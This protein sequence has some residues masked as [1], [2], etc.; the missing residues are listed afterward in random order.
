MGSGVVDPSTTIV[1]KGRSA[2][3]RKMSSWRPAQGGGGGG[4]TGTGG[5]DGLGLGGLGGWRTLGG[6]LGAGRFGGGFLGLGFL[7]GA[8]DGMVWHCSQ[9]AAL[10]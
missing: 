8:A 7:T 6:V 9:P 2:L 5:G 4:G 10:T 1:K 3:V